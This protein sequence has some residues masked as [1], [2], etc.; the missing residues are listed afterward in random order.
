MKNTIKNLV[1]LLA[2]GGLSSCVAYQDGQAQNNGYYDPYYNAGTYYAPSSYYG[3]GGYYGNDG[4][5]YRNNMNYYYDNGMPYYV[6]R[7]NTRIYVVK[8]T[9]ASNGGN[10]NT[11]TFNNSR[12]STNTSSNTSVRMQNSA[13]P[14]FKTPASAQQNRTQSSSL[15]TQSSN[16]NSAVVAP[17]TS[18]QQTFRNVAPQSSTNTPARTAPAA[19]PQTKRSGVR[20]SR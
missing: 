20:G 8:Q 16:R 4:Y 17:R 1:A 7:N 3:G 14:G 18:N 19:E 13:R 12:S 15:R 2:V 11:A 9:N 5:Y 10:S 6:G